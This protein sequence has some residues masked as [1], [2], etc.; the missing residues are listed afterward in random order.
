MNCTCEQQHHK[1]AIAQILAFFCGHPA[2]KCCGQQPYSAKNYLVPKM[3]IRFS[4]GTTVTGHDMQIILP[5]DKIATYAPAF[6]DKFGNKDVVFGSVPAWSLSDATLGTIAASPDGMTATL[7]PSGKE[8]TAQVQLSVDADVGEGVT[9]V[10]ATGEVKFVAGS[11]FTIS[12]NP[13]VGDA[14]FPAPADPAPADPA[15]VPVPGA[16]TI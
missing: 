9:N 11:L 4:N 6:E 13:T 16:P 1:S 15:P 7:T 12:L 10:T 3:R 5:V 8:G 2:H 14:P